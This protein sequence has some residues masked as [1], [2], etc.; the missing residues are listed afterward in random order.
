MIPCLSSDDK[1]LNP[2]S[3]HI[4]FI[5]TSG[6]EKELMENNICYVMAINNLQIS[7]SQELQYTIP[8]GPPK[9]DGA[10]V[11]YNKFSEVPDSEIYTPL[12]NSELDTIR[13]STLCE[14][15]GT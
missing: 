2:K 6:D 9:K 3:C 14:D 8:D 7:V 4:Q 12:K 10:P 11:H 1:Q 13:Y 15:R 5:S